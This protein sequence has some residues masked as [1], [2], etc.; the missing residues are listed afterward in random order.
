[1]NWML[2]YCTYI[3]RNVSVCVCVCVCV[4]VYTYTYIYTFIYNIL[5]SDACICQ[6][7]DEFISVNWLELTTIYIAY[8]YD[9]Y[10]YTIDTHIHKYVSA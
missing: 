1:M 3:Y 5:T 2:L 9:A 10:M 8:M 4:Y 7:S 6:P